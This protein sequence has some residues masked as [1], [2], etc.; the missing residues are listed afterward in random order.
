MGLH[1]TPYPYTTTGSLLACSLQGEIKE[2]MQQVSGKLTS[3][4]YI[5][6]SQIM[7]TSHCLYAVTVHCNFTYS[8]KTNVSIQNKVKRGEAMQSG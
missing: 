3:L 2:A 1:S 6:W 7:T 8:T 5:L 4:A